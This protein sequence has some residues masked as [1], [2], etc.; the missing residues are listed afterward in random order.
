MVLSNLN[1]FIIPK[2]PDSSLEAEEQ[3]LALHPPECPPAVPS[4]RT[5]FPGDAER[6][7]VASDQA[8]PSLLPGTGRTAS[9]PRERH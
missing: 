7:F 6:D 1:N 3:L 8:V 9:V 4:P 2:V 5:S